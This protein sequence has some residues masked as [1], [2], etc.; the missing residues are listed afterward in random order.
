MLEKTWLAKLNEYKTLK[1]TRQRFSNLNGQ[2][3]IIQMVDAGYL[4]FSSNDYLGLASDQRVIASLQRYASQFGVGSGAS[5]LITGHTAIH[6]QLEAYLKEFLGCE[7]VL[8]FSNGFMANLSVI[9]A[10]TSKH[11]AIFQDRLNHASLIDASRFSL[12]KTFRYLHCDM[13]SLNIQLSRNQ[14]KEKLIVT[15]HVFSMDG[16]IAPLVAIK[17]I[18]NKYQAAL[19]IDDA[20]G[21]GVLG[22]FG[23]EAAN[24]LFESKQQTPS[25]YMATL[26][27]AVGTFGA[28]VGGNELIIENLIQFARPYIYTTALPPAIAGATLHSLQIIKSEPER[29][30]TLRQ[31]IQFFKLECKRASI[32]LT[33]SETAIQPVIVET[34]EKA[35]LLSDYLKR[36]HKILAFAI[37]PPTV[38]KN[39]P[40]I[41]IT[42]SAK[43]TFSDITALDICFKNRL[44]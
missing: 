38:P 33:G 34:V 6:E 37:R 10:L 8:L 22:Q 2:K 40:R 12:G 28:F 23:K 39:K 3:K 29:I 24:E 11:T 25:I 7:S 19:F 15:D 14:A 43:H 17:N 4:N 13:E 1:L 31:N 26:G 32:G 5:H 9:S 41:R 36:E 20:H 21:F 44:S 35:L 16:T 30:E 42:L 18:A 27:K